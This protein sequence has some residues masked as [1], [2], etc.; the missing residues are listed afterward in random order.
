[1]I[2]EQDL[3]AMSME[4]ETAYKLM[5]E[6]CETLGFQYPPSNMPQVNEK[7]E[8]MADPLTTH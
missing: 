7:R 8:R 2:T 6:L 3:F 4:S 1:M 5:R